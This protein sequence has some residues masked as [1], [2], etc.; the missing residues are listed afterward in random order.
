[1]LKWPLAGVG[2]DVSKK[3]N[4]FMPKGM[5]LQGNGS[6]QRPRWHGKNEP[7]Q[8]HHASMGTFLS[9]RGNAKIVLENLVYIMSGLM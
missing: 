2:E 3:K 1:M 8:S 5:Y 7:R 4:Q 9:D 6:G